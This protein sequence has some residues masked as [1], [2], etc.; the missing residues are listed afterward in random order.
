LI[1]P[2]HMCLIILHIPIVIK[3]LKNQFKYITIIF[4]T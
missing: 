1:M 3:K 2:S 4:K